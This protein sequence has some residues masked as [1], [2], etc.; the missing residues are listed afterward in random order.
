MI[1]FPESIKD[2]RPAENPQQKANSLQGGQKKKRVEPWRIEVSP[3][4]LT[5]I[6]SFLL[7]IK[8]ITVKNFQYQK[9]SERQM[10]YSNYYYINS[11]LH[12]LYRKP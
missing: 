10:N 1:S 8:K 6:T 9:S 5:Q 7:T 2:I 3:Q 12:V 11:C 4:Q